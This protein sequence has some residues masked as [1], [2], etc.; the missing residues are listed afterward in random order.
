MNKQDLAEAVA[1]SMWDE[2][3]ATQALGMTLDEIAP[4]RAVISMKVLERM[5]NGHK[6]CHGGYIFTLADSAFAFACNSHNQRV[7]AFQCSITY[8]AP[9]FED[10]VLTATAEELTVQGR[11]GIYDIHVRNQDG[12]HIAEFRGNSRTI[13]GTHIELST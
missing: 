12:A 2:D 6:T 10:D 9:A 5:T 8:L 4:G 11:S 7:V 1:A 13:K 3:E